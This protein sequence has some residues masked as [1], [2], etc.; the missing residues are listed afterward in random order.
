MVKKIQDLLKFTIMGTWHYRHP[1]SAGSNKIIKQNFLL[2]KHVNEVV[3][4]K[5]CAGTVLQ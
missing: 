5:I 2:T 4:T 1:K 3:P